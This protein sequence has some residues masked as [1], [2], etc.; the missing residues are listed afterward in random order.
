MRGVGRS[1]GVGEEGAIPLSR[2]VTTL[3]G[4]ATGANEF[5]FM[6]H[7][8]AESLGIPE[9]YL[10]PALG[11]TRD[12]TSN[13]IRPEDLDA[14]ERSGKPTRLLALNGGERH[15]LPTPV[16]AYLT[17]GEAQGLHLRALLATRNPWY[18]AESRTPPPFLFSYLGRRHARFIKNEAGVVPLTGFLCVYP[19]WSDPTFLA[20]LWAALSHPSTLQGLVQVGKTYG[21][22]SVKVEPRSLARLLI[23]RTAIE[24]SGLSQWGEANARVHGDLR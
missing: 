9:N 20:C 24:E 23:P 22:G 15:L 6:T 3:R 16:Q 21:D 14:L 19:K 17:L 13:V 7:A 1:P 18:K 8:M 5:F 11:K 10:I 4:I 2:F 12:V